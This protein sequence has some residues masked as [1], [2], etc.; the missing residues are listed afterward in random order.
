M[1]G[2]PYLAGSA[3]APSA[4][5]TTLT[6]P[7]STSV[8]AFDSIF[9]AVGVS[10]ASVTVSVSDTA[11]NNYTQI[12]DDTTEATAQ[13]YIFESDG[14]NELVA[15]TD[16]VFVVYS[17]NSSRQAALVIGDNNVTGSDK[18]VIAHGSSTTPSSG[19]SGTLSQAEEHVIGFICSANGGTP[20]SWT[21]TTNVLGTVDGGSSTPT[22][23]SAA[24]VDV[25]A[26]TAVTAGAT[27]SSDPWACAIVTTEVP[28]P[29]VLTTMSDGVANETYSQTLQAS[30]GVGSYTW[31]ISSGTLPTGLS[32]ATG[33][34]S[35]TPTV[36]GTFTFTTKVTDAHS[37]SGTLAQTIILLPSGPGGAPATQFPN[38]LL[39]AADSDFE[40][41]TFTW[42]ADTNAGAP[43]ATS[44]TSL[45]GSH[46]LKWA[47]L[48]AGDTQI[49]TG[50]YTVEPI[51]P[52]IVSGYILPC[53]Q[54]DTM[55]GI[56]WYDNT[57][58]IIETDLGND[59][60][61]SSI[62]WQP[63]VAALT[64]PSNAAYAK[65][66]VVIQE[67][68]AGDVNHI[69]LCYLAQTSAQVLIDW[70]NNP[71]GTGSSAGNDFMD[72]SP[73]VRMDQNISL[74]RGRQDAISDILAGSA[75]FTLQ[76][77]T[78]CFT[79]YKS[80]SIPTV[81]GGDVTLQ[82]RCQINL[83]DEQGVWYTRFDGPISEIDYTGD[84]TGNTNIALVSVTDILAPLN[85]QDD[86]SCWSEEQVLADGPWLHWGLDDAGNA[87]G[88]GVA[89]ESSG[90]N[91]PPM[92]LWNS[93][94]T[95]KATIGFQDTSGGV[96]TLADA[97]AAGESDGSEYWTPGSN[98]PNSYL[99]GLDSGAVGPYTTP[100]GSALLTPT[101]TA[102]SAVNYFTGNTGYQF[103]VTLPE[104]IEPWESGTDYTCET[105]F[106]VD[107]TVLA[108][109]ASKYGPYIVMSLGTARLGTCL[110]AGI[111]LTG[112]TPYT[113]TVGTYNQPPA[114]LG[115][116]FSGSAP[117]A[118]VSSITQSLNADSVSIPHHLVLTISGDP[119]APSISAWLDGVQFS[120]SLS[121]PKRQYYDTF[122]I[123][124]AFGGMGCHFGNVSLASIYQYELSSTQI[125][126]HCMLGQYGMWEQTTDDC[127][128]ALTNFAD[129]PSFW[130]NI[131][132]NHNGLTMTDYQDITGVNALGNMQLYEAAEG[133]LLFVDAS[134][135]LNFH[136]RDWRMGYGAPDLSLPPD[137]FDADMGY[138]LIDQYQQNET[139]VSTLIYTQGTAYVNTQSQEAYGTYAPNGSGFA[140][141]STTSTAATASSTNN[142]TGYADSPLQLPL[143][144][145]NRGAG[146]LG[147]TSFSYW[148]DPNL[149][150]YAAWNAN[151]YGNP[152]FTPGQLTFD[153]L[154]MSPT[155]GI[156][157]SDL[158]ALEI[159]NMV[160]PTGTLPSSWPD[161][162]LSTEWFIEG[163]NE[164]IGESTRTFQ[165]YCSPAETQRAWIPGDET[166]GVLGSTSRIGISQAD[167]STPQADGK[168]VSH[169]AGR[170]YWP[171]T[172]DTTMNNPSGNGNSFIGEL[173]IRGLTDNLSL[174]L[175]PPM[176]VVG[177]IS[178]TQSQ[179]SGS[180]SSPQVF[181]DTIFVDTVGGMGAIP[182][183][184]N[185]YVCLVP[186]FYEID[187][188]LVWERQSSGQSNTTSQSWIVIAQQGAQT[189]STGGSPL[190]ATEYVCPIGESSNRNASSINSVEAPATRI[191]LG[192]GDMVT[193]AAEQNVGSA[194]GTGTDFHGSVFS[195]RWVGYSTV[196]DRV[197]LNSTING[198]TSSQK[199]TSTTYNNT[200]QNTH[201]YSYYGP[202]GEQ[203]DARRNQDGSVYQGTYSGGYY[204]D[205]SQCAQV[206]WPHAQIN[207]DLSQ[208]N[209]VINSV[210]LKC[211][212]Q[213][214][215][216]DS[217]AKLMLGYSITTP[218]GGNF[219]ASGVEN[220]DVFEES[221]DEGQTKTFTLSKAFATTFQGSGKMFVV[222][223]S[224]TQNLDY[225]GYWEGG[226]NT[227]ELTINFTVTS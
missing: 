9:I 181:W 106:T 38:N 199:Q 146:A 184:P 149:V 44:E 96:E 89:A 19:S 61:S 17:S 226:P 47:S 87:G 98:Q 191:Y 174:L 153:I 42:A 22:Y 95:N 170:P 27:I 34:I 1:S 84:N 182:G 112:S 129:V 178:E 115:K 71:F 31:S 35:G 54:R 219:N 172:F 177:A 143:I 104:P 63:V 51:K 117:P 70:Q 123:G 195:L 7:I 208:P 66:V 55:I 207:S 36:S 20:S 75:T 73:F 127:I 176:C 160:T 165:M 155:T 60:S 136:T 145:W 2:T 125:V 217:G 4:G 227:W 90:N 45:T 15:G 202:T 46:S 151:S 100:I 8:N 225:Y 144:T 209:T 187:A 26:T 183:W 171:P 18:A 39:T 192:L 88:S 179:G 128:N 166:Y 10:F 131:S 68:N 91:G 148:S 65:V 157:I 133:G 80:T 119:S 190:S 162:N 3:G 78:G 167:L 185:W 116:N 141:A 6:V 220:N 124:G 97:V 196:D 81:L 102:Q 43:A 142:T 164:T 140:G 16:E 52:Y 138:E 120:S 79:P 86:L 13:L 33:V 213:H 206:V 57:H 41:G 203:G 189:V 121:L 107:P 186:G 67:S 221:F 224:T 163:I 169:D 180:L 62:A 156:A 223:N 214:T 201:T 77:D 222:G 21:G 159:D 37:V 83:T 204:V 139:A 137:T 212:N 126:N 211:K 58:T 82:R 11:G 28:A 111:Y 29:T 53:G 168:D 150:D 101:L 85:R 216:Y 49:S 210:T 218:G 59:T 12:L 40:T 158:Y 56:E 32:L 69:D 50:Y 74:S 93:D 25:T 132:G 110:V 175:Q 161:Q 122:C 72:V 152:W 76:N 205:G 154:T 135:N 194:Q 23:V 109:N 197:Q 188:S 118:L 215:W 94:H 193:I 200:Y 113:F 198:G 114:F 14:S 5:S 134:G 99:R 105:W 64:S 24:Y 173:D 108:D 103:Q 147:L 130:S 92:R 48:A 30:G